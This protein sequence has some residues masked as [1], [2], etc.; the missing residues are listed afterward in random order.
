MDYGYS[1]SGLIIIMVICFICI[2]SELLLPCGSLLLIVFICGIICV[3]VG[4][5]KIYS[6]N[7]CDNIVYKY[8][9]KTFRELQEQP[10]SVY[11]SLNSLFYAP[12]PWLGGYTFN[13]E[14]R[15]DLNQYFISQA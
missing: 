4:L 1:G 8:V 3:A 7:V 5:T 15:S 6:P 13:K 9:P 11:E 10:L 2:F 12:S 14:L